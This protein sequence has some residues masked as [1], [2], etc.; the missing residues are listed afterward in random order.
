MISYVVAS[1]RDWFKNHLK[2][3]D[4]E[5]LNIVE[6]SNKDDLNPQVL[7][8]INP[9]YIFFPHWSWI[10]EPEIYEKFE[11]VVFHTAP[12]PFGRGGSPIQNMIIRGMEKS[13]LCAIKMTSIID[14]GA[15]YDSMDVS[16]HGTITEIFSGI[17]QATDKLIVKI[18]QNNPEP[19]DQTGEITVFKRLTYADNELLPQ[20]SI[21]AIY[22]RVRMV[23][24]SGYSKAYINF[25]DY[26][27]EFSQAKILN[28]ELFANIR[29]FA[30]EN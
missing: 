12:L 1:S 29:L 4:Y 22:D 9:R 17:A 28:N 23:D 2:S 27:I 6:I 14:G 11:C 5:K 8:K 20:Y 13:P 24:G 18:C 26:K 16:L 19:R 25:G 30:D 7:N 3:P 21:K 15:I 10:V